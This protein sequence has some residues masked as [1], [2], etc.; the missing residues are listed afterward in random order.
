MFGRADRAG[1]LYSARNEDQWETRRAVSHHWM[2]HHLEEQQLILH[3]STTVFLA[4][5][6]HYFT[7]LKSLLG[8]FFLVTSSN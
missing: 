4:L 8:T 5:Y 6:F 1:L 2:F 7:P 3:C